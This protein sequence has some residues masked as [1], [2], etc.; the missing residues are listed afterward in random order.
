MVCAVGTLLHGKAVFTVSE[1]FEQIAEL[2]VTVV[3]L[4]PYRPELKGTVEKFFDQIQE[5]YK[6]YLKGKGVI[7]PDFQERGAHDYRKDACLTIRDFEKENLQAQI[8]LAQHIE[9]IANSVSCVSC[10]K[11]ENDND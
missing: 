7:E 4:P 2:G 3:N 10:P 9:A 11:E 1:N 8:S 6:K 5:T